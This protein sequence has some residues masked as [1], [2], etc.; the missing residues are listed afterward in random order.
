MTA[1]SITEPG[2]YPDFPIDVYHSDPTPGPSLTQSLAKIILDSSCAH[3]MYQHPKFAKVRPEEDDAEK[4]VKAR[5]IGDVAHKLILGRGKDIA[6]IDAAD[7]RTKAAKE[8]RDAAYAA[9]KL[10]ILRAH[11]DQAEA[12]AKFFTMFL[13]VHEAGPL[14]DGDSEVAIFWQEDGIWFRALID[15]LS[16]DR[17]VIT[18]LKTTSLVVP[19]HEAGRRMDDSG[20]QIQAA[21]IDR[22]LNV[23]D[24]EN[25]GKR[26]YR[27]ISI[28]QNP[29]FGLVVNQLSEAVLTLGRKQLQQ[30]V[31][32][33]IECLRNGKWPCY[34]PVTNFPETPSY[35]LTK[36]EAREQEMIWGQQQ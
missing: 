17:R 5:A 24:P 9:G 8:A 19:P 3:A 32:Q 18:D 10:P 30:A 25:A 4:Y 27:F 29:P 15:H 13:A 26:V 12:V 34:A 22:G 35:A 33:W 23:L 28:E 31:F 14:P 36:W 1:T 11:C 6:I 7:M 16:K 20:W 21:Q 2:I